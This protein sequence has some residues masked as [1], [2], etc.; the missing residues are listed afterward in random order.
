MKGKTDIIDCLRMGGPWRCGPDNAPENRYE[1]V[2]PV[3]VLSLA[4]TLCYG[5][6]R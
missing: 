5:A 2:E 4:E 1:P 6:I 3:Q